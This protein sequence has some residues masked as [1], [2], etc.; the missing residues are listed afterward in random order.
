M[1][2]W[3][4]L[5]ERTLTQL[6]IIHLPSKSD[7]S[8]KYSRLNRIDYINTRL[9]FYMALHCRS[10]GRAAYARNHSDDYEMLGSSPF[11]TWVDALVSLVSLHFLES[12]S[13]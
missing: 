6:Y 8:W 11:V 10:H 1:F 3:P 5:L 2:Q 7:K 13:K 4:E 12:N 9:A